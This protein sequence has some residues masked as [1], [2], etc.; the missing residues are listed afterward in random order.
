MLH[1][2][3]QFIIQGIDPQTDTPK[4]FACFIRS[5]G[6]GAARAIGAA[7]VGSE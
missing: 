5:E 4:G 6:K 3:E 7:G 1:I 2:H